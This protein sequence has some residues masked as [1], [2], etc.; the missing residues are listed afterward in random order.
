MQGT[1]K[2]GADKINNGDAK[3]DAQPPKQRKPKGKPGAGRGR[4]KPLSGVL[5]PAY[6]AS[7][8]FHRP[9]PAKR[10]APFE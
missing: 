4:G 8:A 9:R 10:L 5:A 2:G 3:R 1:G 6:D 7:F